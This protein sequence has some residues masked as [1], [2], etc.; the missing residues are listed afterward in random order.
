MTI[1]TLHQRLL[2]A[3]LLLVFVSPAL[4]ATFDL[5]SILDRTAISPPSRVGFREIRHNR[6]LKDDL[7]F[8]GYLE[9]PQ[10]GTLRKVIETPFEESYLMQ[11]NRI[12]VQRNGETR[13]L[14]AQTGRALSTTLG[15]IEA[16]LAGDAGQLMAVFEYELNGTADDWSLRLLPRSNRIA[17]QLI[18]LTVS[19]DATA[20]RSIRFDLKDGE[21]HQM[22]IVHDAGPPQ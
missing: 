18:S 12:E 15:G 1:R 2:F 9:Y 16:L 22:D 17:R 11:S 21:W 3:C 20:V 5:Q 19:G 6:L 13:V 7:I 8:T 14:S 4:P 10:S